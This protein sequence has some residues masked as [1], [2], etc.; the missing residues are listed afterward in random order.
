[1]GSKW[2]VP[3]TYSAMWVYGEDAVDDSFENSGME[4][5]AMKSNHGLDVHQCFPK[6]IS[7]KPYETSQIQ[8]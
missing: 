2:D 1:M 4:T 3:G 5:K 8:P 7:T 6:R